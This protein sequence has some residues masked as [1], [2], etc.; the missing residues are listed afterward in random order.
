MKKYYY[1]RIETL[2]LMYLLSGSS[3]LRYPYLKRVNDQCLALTRNY[4]SSGF[5]WAGSCSEV[6]IRRKR[7]SNLYWLVSLDLIEITLLN[8]IN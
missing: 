6:K 8:T 4:N 7:N 2:P 5:Q 1:L 3:I